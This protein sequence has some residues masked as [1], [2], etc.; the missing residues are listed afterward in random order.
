[1]AR[2]RFKKRGYSVWDGPERDW[3]RMARKDRVKESKKEDLWWVYWS[4]V[5][6]WDKQIRLWG[7]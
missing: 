7:G 2:V 3:N 6:K 5:R 4:E 1:M